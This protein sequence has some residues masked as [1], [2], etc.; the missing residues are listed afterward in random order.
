MSENRTSVLK[1]KIHDHIKGALAEL[2]EENCIQI[3]EVA[4]QLLLDGLKQRL[5]KRSYLQ[6]R[7]TFALLQG[8]F[9]DPK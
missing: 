3:Q 5:V 4:Y 8:N 2:A 1:F 6:D 9:G 7:R